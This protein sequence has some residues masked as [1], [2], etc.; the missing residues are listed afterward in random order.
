M[1][2]SFKYTVTDTRTSTLIAKEQDNIL[3]ADIMEEPYIPDP[4]LSGLRS[5]HMECQYEL[6]YEAFSE[7][8]HRYMTGKH[9][10]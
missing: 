2:A 6:R 1:R 9:V 8:M 10:K 7:R 3:I 4:L 5:K